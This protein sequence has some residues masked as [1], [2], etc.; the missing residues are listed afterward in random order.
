MLQMNWSSYVYLHCESHLAWGLSMKYDLLFEAVFIQVKWT[1]V[2]A[3]NG[4]VHE[5]SAQSLATKFNCAEA[6]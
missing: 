2:T 6:R 5:H 1:P 4:Y 3:D